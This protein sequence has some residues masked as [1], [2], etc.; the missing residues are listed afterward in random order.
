MI[1]QHLFVYYA[2]VSNSKRE[3]ER[4]RERVKNNGLL[5][6]K[7]K[8]VKQRFLVILHIVQNCILIIFFIIFFSFSNFTDYM[9]KIPIKKLTF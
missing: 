2:L 7:T 5:N 9:K 1:W 8:S 6:F 3:R 4:E